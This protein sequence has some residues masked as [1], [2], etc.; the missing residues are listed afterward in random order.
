MRN[1][2]THFAE[3]LNKPT[4]DVQILILWDAEENT[5]KY[6]KMVREGESDF[7]K[8]NEILNVRFDLMNR[9]AICNNFIANT[10]KKYAIQFKCE[11][12]NLFVVIYLIEDE[13]KD[14]RLF[15]Y[16]NSEALKEIELEE[17]LSN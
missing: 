2:I 6:K 10:L 13:E 1:G 17:I 11:M 9:E 16:K 3:Q 15:L 4:A 12:S 8:F 14:I 5:I 7:V